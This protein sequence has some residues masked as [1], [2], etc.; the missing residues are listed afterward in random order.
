M[1]GSTSL[2]RATRSSASS[3]ATAAVT[4]MPKAVRGMKVE[5]ADEQ[6]HTDGEEDVVE[7]ADEAELLLVPERDGALPLAPL[8]ELAQ[9]R[10]LLGGDD[11]LADRSVEIGVLQHRGHPPS[12]Q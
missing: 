1:P 12:F 6:E 10:G 4:A 3:H 8:R 7:A 2:R 5:P 11:A 9:G